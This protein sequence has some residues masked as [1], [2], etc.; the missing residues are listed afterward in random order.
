MNF[1]GMEVSNDTLTLSL[2]GSPF[3][4]HL[5]GTRDDLC[6]IKHFF[7]IYADLRKVFAANPVFCQDWQVNCE[8]Q[9]I[10]CAALLL[11]G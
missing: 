4:G 6:L 1:N 11:L 7:I 3:G 5:K 8:A 10:G 9:V 2:K